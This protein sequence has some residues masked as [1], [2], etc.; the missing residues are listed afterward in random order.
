[1]APPLIQLKDIALTFGG[2]PLL[3]GAELTV[4]AGEQVSLVGRNGSG[5]IHAAQDAAGLASPTVARFSM[6]QARS[7]LY[8]P[9]GR[10]S[11]AFSTLTVEASRGRAD[12]ACA[13]APCWRPWPERAEDPAQMSGG[14]APRLA[15]PRL[16]PAPDILLLESRPI[17]LDPPHPNGRAGAPRDSARDHQPRSAFPP[18]SR[19]ARSGSTAA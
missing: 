7:F 3:T 4:A 12:D 5:Q 1:M 16:A 10:T 18:T 13:R 8:L 9:Q 2:T 11:R 19:A 15:S 6:R 14:G 17:H